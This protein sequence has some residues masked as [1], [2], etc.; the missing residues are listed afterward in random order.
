MD[1]VTSDRVGGDLSILLGVGDGTFRPAVSYAVD[2]E[3][4]DL[5]AKKKR[6]G[7]ETFESRAQKEP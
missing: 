2:P 1:L 5:D 6:V 4:A 3:P 7:E